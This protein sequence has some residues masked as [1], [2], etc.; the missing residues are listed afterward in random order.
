MEAM[1]KEGRR[2]EIMPNS[3]DSKDRKRKR[4]SKGEEVV[5]RK[6]KGDKHT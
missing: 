5:V 1:G 4:R 3:L 6:G 2:K